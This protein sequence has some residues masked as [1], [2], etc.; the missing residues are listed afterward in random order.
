MPGTLIGALADRGLSVAEL[1]GRKEVDLRDVSG[2][3]LSQPIE[4]PEFNFRHLVCFEPASL[5][6][7]PPDAV[8]DLFRSLFP[9]VTGEPWISSVAVPVL[10]AGNQGAD[11]V[12]MMRAILDAA[13][14]WL[15]T[16]LPLPLMK[17]VVFDKAPPSL[18][19]A[20]TDTFRQHKSAM[21]AVA[22]ESR[23]TDDA[24]YDL[25]VSYSHV[26]SDVVHRLVDRIAQLAPDI[27]VFLDRAE[28]DAGAAW[29]QNIF[30]AIDA[31]RRVVCVFSP[32]Y[33]R[34]RVCMEE[35]NIAHL[36]NREEDGVLVPAYLR[37][38]DKLPSYMRLVQ[39]VDVREGDGQRLEH[40]AR[41]LVDEVPAS[42]QAPTVK[43]PPL[44]VSADDLDVV[45]MAQAL[46]DGK[47]LRFE[48]R[49]RRI[50]DA[51]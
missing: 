16:G 21:G 50:D 44:S 17:I 38:T 43:E 6:R 25:F 12:E 2:C 18:L 20:V 30:R 51:P 23:R 37:S 27:R 14:H 3:W 8:G 36:R 45:R 1:A 41:Q 28:L 26:D 7:S 22:A 33:L 10:A 32:D 35:Y 34:S 4:R 13:S 46:V 48:V 11:P 49:I 42:A 40:L 47:E 5:K 31:S 39:Y 15:S 29:Q 9:Y 19:A 24:R